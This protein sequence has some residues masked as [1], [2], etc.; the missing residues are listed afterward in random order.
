MAMVSCCDMDIL[1]DGCSNMETSAETSS[2]ILEISSGNFE[3]V[4]RMQGMISSLKDM[5]EKSRELST[6]YGCH[7]EFC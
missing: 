2:N 1:E 7:E 3:K 6:G 4:L 5:S